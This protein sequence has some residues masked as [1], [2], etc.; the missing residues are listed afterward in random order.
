MR[1]SDINGNAR[2]NVAILTYNGQMEYVSNNAGRLQTTVEIAQKIL[3]RQSLRFVNIW[4][5]NRIEVTTT[6]HGNPFGA[7]YG[8]VN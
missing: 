8:K 7:T 6:L 3:R 5:Q 4:R 1:H 2:E